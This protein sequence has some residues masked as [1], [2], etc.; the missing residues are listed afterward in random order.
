MRAL[1]VI[2]MQKGGFNQG[3]IR[4]DSDK[5]I[6][7]INELAAN[8]RNKGDKVIF[9]QHDGSAEGL[10][11]PQ[12]KD[13]EILD[14]LKVMPQDHIISKTANDSFYRSSLEKQ[15]VINDINEVYVC[16]WA[17]DFCVD[18]TIRSALSKDFS[19]TV[20]ADAHTTADRPE[21]NA[22]QVINHHNWLWTELT[23]T[24]GNV[25][26]VESCH[27]INEMAH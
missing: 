21:L 20:I 13:W 10:F 17:T 18:S 6:K 9:I 5:V 22:K 25:R 4:Y 1:L 11:I 14:E 23:P 19:V 16:G 8:F 26:V 12:T 3:I 24:I 27:L 15:L 7:L 2:D